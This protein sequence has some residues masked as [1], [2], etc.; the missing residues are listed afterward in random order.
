[1]ISRPLGRCAVAIADR[2]N[3]LKR[4]AAVCSATLAIAI[5]SQTTTTA[6]FEDKA[7]GEIVEVYSPG[8][9][10]FR[11]TYE[12]DAFNRSL[13]TWDQYWSWVRTF[14][15]GNF[16]S[17]GWT[18]ETQATIQVV[19]SPTS[20]RAVTRLLNEMGRDVA[21]EWAKETA[22]RKIHLADV[23]RWGDKIRSA[24]ES[25]DGGGTAI[26]VAA[27]EIRAEIGK[28]LGR[29]Q[30]SASASTAGSSTAP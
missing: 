14:Y 4:L 27:R 1:M 7:D 24:R 13:Q 11:E 18:R 28:K 15:N 22:A 25:D 30:S 10:Y 29:D 26:L 16:L 3:S 17:R 20:R 19:A 5:L 2:W 8:A 21:A 9:G 23:K 12:K 6:Q